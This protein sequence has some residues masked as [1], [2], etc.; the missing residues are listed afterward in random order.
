VTYANSGAAVTV[1]LNKQ[2]GNAGGDAENDHLHGFDNLIGSSHHDVLTGDNGNNQIEGGAGNDTLAGGLGNDTLIGG[3]LGDGGIDTVS[4]AGVS[5]AVTASL[6]SGG[7]TTTIGGGDFDSYVRIDN[8]IGGSGN[9]TLSGNDLDNR[10]DGGGGVDTASWATVSAPLVVS[11]RFGPGAAGLATGEGNDV[12]I[13]IENLHG[14]MG[15]DI[16]EGNA[17]ANDFT[18]GGGNDTVSY[19]LSPEVSGSTGVF[20]SIDPGFGNSY[21]LA[22]TGDAAGDRYLYFSI[23]NLTGS[24]FNDVLQGDANPLGNHFHGG[25][26][27]ND[28]VTY[29]NSTLYVVASLKD[30]TGVDGDAAG[31]SYESIENLTGS[32]GHDILTGDDLANV[33]NGG[34]GNDILI[35]GLGK[36]TLDGGGGVDTVS[37][38]Y[39]GTSPVTA[40]LSSVGGSG[41]TAIPGDVDTYILIRNLTG[42]AGDDTLT[43]NNEANIIEGGSGDDRLEGLGGPDLFYGGGGTDTVTFITSTSS[44]MTSLDPSNPMRSNAASGDLYD[45]IE[46]LQGTNL[47]LGDVLEGNSGNNRIEGLG[48]PDFLYGLAGNDTLSG[49]S[50]SDYLDGGAGDDSLVGGDSQTDTLEGG[51]GADILQG[52]STSFDFASYAGATGPV[53]AYLGVIGPN[54][55][56]GSDA[57]GDRYVEIN[58]LI[59][60]DND[61]RL[62]GNANGNS[63]VGGDG[64]DTVTY[65]H[66]LTGVTASLLSFGTQ[67][68]AIGDSYSSIENL[69]GGAGNDNLI[70]NDGVNQLKGGAGDDTLQGG[71]KPLLGPGDTLS[72]G[73]GSD[74]AS[75]SL[76]IAAVKASL[77]NPGDNSGDAAGDSYVSIEG[78]IGSIYNDTLEGDAIKDDRLEGGAG[79]DILTGGGGSDTVSYRNALL[80]GVAA[81]L[82][83]ANLADNTGDAEGDTY[84]DVIENLEGSGHADTLEGDGNANIISG[85]AGN[86]TITGGAGADKL[87]G[88]AGDDVLKGG[89]GADSLVGGGGSDW[90]S[91]A[92][93]AAPVNVYLDNSLLNGGGDEA[94][95][96]YTDIANLLGSTGNDTLEGTSGAN[97]FNGGGGGSDTV[98]YAHSTVPLTALLGSGG[99]LGDALGDTYIGIAN[100]VGGSGDDRLSGDG[101]ANRLEGGLGNDMLEGGAGADTLVGGAGDSDTASYAGA[102][103]GTGVFAS[104][105]HSTFNTGD[106]LGDLYLGDILNLLGSA[107][108]DTLEGTSGANDFTGGGGVDTVTYQNSA[109]GVSAAL[110]SG[111]TAGDA[112]GDRYFDI[113]N[114]TG[115]S[116]NDSLTGDAM[117][118]VLS[119]GNGND[120]LTGGLGN[121]SLDGGDGNDVIDASAGNDA[122]I[123]DIGNDL[124]QVALDQLPASVAGQGGLDMLEIVGLSS[125]IGTV[126]L[127][128]FASIATGIETINVRNGAA[129]STV[130]ID[131]DTIV[132]LVGGATP[133]LNILVDATGDSLDLS[134]F[135]VT[136][137]DVNSTA[138][139]NHI[140]YT[141][142]NLASTEVVMV[143]WTWP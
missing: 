72:G 11:L 89:A 62:E 56:P 133:T 8:L 37:Y 52:D 80:V 70:G 113:A 75:Y 81:T 63:F 127:R 86:D 93:S 123:G 103:A 118:N 16:L 30:K 142:T 55:D 13:N 116:H 101:N 74:M 42:G 88:G 47:G 143:I 95:D 79:A 69:T 59:G 120:T 44:V 22:Q 126:D 132:N 131:F 117:G 98:T 64:T 33:I 19:A 34:A 54:I 29:L 110:D 21:W 41:G 43:G 46:N 66:S 7:G 85:L 109:G 137:Y 60:S 112:S 124:I 48:G 39:A 105:G 130:Q 67:G 38:A 94:E 4:Y 14:G 96:T 36:D 26:S 129:N 111:G 50:G 9:D 57:H 99:T 32:S 77:E 31:D 92:N 135:P 128:A 58:N 90:A 140:D 76:A 78:L 17:G 97:T 114:L 141:I 24:A 108:N 91:Y 2:T 35:G 83:L 51:A 45:D 121:D 136:D 18:G 71:A 134:P 139:G 125:G 138:T 119:G 61:D 5:A 23:R 87:Y 65:E 49:G 10:I 68:D 15:D 115:S 27:G 1:L 6:A 53:Y 104:L 25:T 82:D 122:V 73:D 106:A 40:T 3:V 102:G 100:L 107:S 12:L 28:T 84:G 20:A